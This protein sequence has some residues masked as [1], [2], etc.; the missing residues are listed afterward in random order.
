M[1]EFIQKLDAWR[2]RFKNAGNPRNLLAENHQRE[3]R[4]HGDCFGAHSYGK[5]AIRRWG[6]GAK[7]SVG[8]FCSIADGVTVFLGGNHRS[9]WITTYPFSDFAD[10]WPGAQGHPSTLSSR[11]DVTIG[12]DVWIGA[13]ATI[14]SG[15]TIGH[16]AIVGARAVVGRDVAP[17]AVV[18]G[19]PALEVKRRFPPPEAQQLLA[20]AWWDLPDETIDRLATLLQ[21]GDVAALVAAAQALKGQ[22]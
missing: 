10:R 6:E 18:V 3:A 2:K 8:K 9:D 21:S 12:H 4:L 5:L 17:Y 7:L 20:L 13:G 22:S 14:L 11:G 16:G 1:R 19:N 15:V